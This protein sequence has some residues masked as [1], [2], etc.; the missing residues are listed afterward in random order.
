MGEVPVRVAGGRDALVHLEEVDLLPGDVLS[1]ERS[2]HPPRRL[3]A[4][5][6]ER[7]P[8]AGGHR[9]ARRGGEPAAGADGDRAGVGE[10]LDLHGASTPQD[11]AR[12]QPPGTSSSAAFGPQVPGSYSWIGVLAWIAGSTIRHAS[13]T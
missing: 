3:P 4:A 1:R 9:V 13:S 7:E 12:N 6:R 10:G 5:D 11:F 8:A 2:Q